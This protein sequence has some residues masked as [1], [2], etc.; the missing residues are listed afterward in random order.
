MLPAIE[1]FEEELRQGVEET[2]RDLL[3]A[4]L[5]CWEHDSDLTLQSQCRARELLCEYGRDR[6][7]LDSNKPDG[8]LYFLHSLGR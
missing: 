5:E 6:R 3:V 8:P 1:R 2:R 4:I 7:H